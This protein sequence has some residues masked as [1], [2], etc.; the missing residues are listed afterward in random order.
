MSSRSAILPRALLCATL[1]VTPAMPVVADSTATAPP[2][3]VASQPVVADSTATA[4]P[5]VP[6]PLPGG[7]NR[8]T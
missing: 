3:A 8:F 6:V 1:A 5:A 4:A 7:Q 2:A